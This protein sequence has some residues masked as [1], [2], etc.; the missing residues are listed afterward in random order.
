M[1]LENSVVLADRYS[2]EGVLDNSNPLAFIYRAKDL[3]TEQNVVVREFFPTAFTQRLKKKCGVEVQ[4]RELFEYGRSIF[5]LEAKAL[6]GI[7]HPNVVG[8]V[9]SFLENETVYS[10]YDAFAGAP[11]ANSLDKRG[12]PFTEPEA[13]P[14]IISVLDGL[15][16]CHERQL[17]HGGISPES[18]YMLPTQQLLLRDFQMANIQLA[19]ICGNVKDIRRKGFSPPEI[20]KPKV[21]AGPWWDIFSSAATLFYMVTGRQLPSVSNKASHTRMIQTLDGTDE[22]SPVLKEVFHRALAYDHEARPAT[23][24]ELIVM[25]SSVHGEGLSLESLYNFD[26]LAGTDVGNQESGY[27]L[28]LLLGEKYKIDY[29]KEVGKELDAEKKR[30]AKSQSRKKKSPQVTEERS[31]AVLESLSLPRLILLSLLMIGIG[32]VGGYLLVS[33]K[34]GAPAAGSTPTPEVVQPA[35]VEIAE[36]E[37]GE[38]MPVDSAQTIESAPHPLEVLF[39][40]KPPAKEAADSSA[41]AASER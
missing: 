13:I 33:S 22:I 25:L 35:P 1:F 15:K 21:D 32:M 27:E 8:Q 7:H 41:S 39:G 11:L 40:K 23:L 37:D 12:F 16:H 17:Y 20:L 30:S 34:G 18:I 38:E 10:V 5:D 19:Q 6:G 9:A 3:Y 24:D 36:P 4:E 26:S 14:L 2:I 28:D 31:S 29:L